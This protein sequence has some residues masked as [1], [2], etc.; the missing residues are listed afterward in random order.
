[1]RGY[2][3]N[4]FV[5]SGIALFFGV[6]MAVLNIYPS[7]S[8]TAG[9]NHDPLLYSTLFCIAS[10]FMIASFGHPEKKRELTK[11]FIVG[12]FSLGQCFRLTS[13]FF[14]GVIAF[15]VNNEFSIIET[16]HLI[17]TGLGILTGYIGLITYPETK[18]GHTWA[19]IGT[20]LG[21]GGFLVGFLTNIYSI[22]WGEVLAAIPL[23]I[24]MNMT[25]K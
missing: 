15:S 14:G 1:M 6:L 2:K 11:F 25:F 18:K 10:S 21:L 7:W 8:Q 12:S 3:L 16:F 17:F 20:C 22:S 13:Y 23:A 9:T 5:L 19:F 24:W 4:V